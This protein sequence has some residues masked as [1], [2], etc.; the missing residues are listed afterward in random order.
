MG[1]NFVNQIIRRI[2]CRKLPGFESLPE[3]FNPAGPARRPRHVYDPLN[4]AKKISPSAAE[5]HKYLAVYHVMSNFQY[6]SALAEIK[7]YNIKTTGSVFG[8]NLQGFLHHKLREYEKAV[9]YFNQSLEIQPSVYAYC[10]LSRAEAMIFLTMSEKTP[11]RS[12]HRKR[13]VD[14]HATARDLYR[15]HWRVSM[16]EHWLRYKKIL[17]DNR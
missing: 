12:R 15:D 8:Y 9:A 4:R 16:L 10:K 2:A 5:P 14:A 3:F 11:G 17:N 1:V 7:E 6:K 13:A